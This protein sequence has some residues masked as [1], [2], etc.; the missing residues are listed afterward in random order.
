MTGKEKFDTIDGL[1]IRRGRVTIKIMVPACL[2][3]RFVVEAR[4]RFGL[5]VLRV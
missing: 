2:R 1:K 5:T 4:N 3:G